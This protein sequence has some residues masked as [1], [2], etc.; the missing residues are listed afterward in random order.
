VRALSLL[1]LA[2]A[3]HAETRTYIVAVGNNAPP[4]ESDG[5]ELAPLRYADDD[6][7]AFYSFGR[8][9]ARSAY[10]LTVLDAA[11]QRRFPGL[12]EAA[13]PPTLA[14]L[15]RVVDELGRRFEADAREGHEPV[16]LL[17]FSGHGTRGGKRPP[18][19]ALLDEPLTQAVLYDDILSRLPARYVHLLVDAC[20]AEA[21]VRPRDT[22]AQP[23]DVT[24]EDVQTYAARAT[25]QR[26]PQVG[27]VLATAAGVQAHE[28]DAYQRGVFSHELLSALRG[29]ADVNGDGRIEYSELAAFLGA[30]NREVA[31]PRARL[32]VVIRPPSLNG[33]APL[34]D[35]TQLRGAVKLTG[36]A[37]GGLYVEDELGNRLADFHSEPGHPVVLLLPSD[38]ALFVHHGRREARLDAAAG[39]TIRLEELRFAESGFAAR[40]ALDLSLQRGL[41]ATAYG[42]RYYR[43]YVDQ[44]QELTPVPVPDEPLVTQ[45]PKVLVPKRTTGIALV[46]VGAGL[47]ATS[48]VL[49]GLAGDTVAHFPGFERQATD[50]KNRALAFESTAL[51]AAAL[52]LVAGGVGTWLMVRGKRPVRFAANLEW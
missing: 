9:V 27:A 35:T 38:R 12:A 50:A 20:H 11:S 33:R 40:G 1:L 18:S 52:A 37:A 30:A 47:A 41:F 7:A 16:L 45:P 2:A 24:D 51:T 48:I 13:R 5:E 23:V 39:A 22:S 21:V 19:L 10:L 42:P 44:N 46:A 15:K 8:A 26:F 28:W 34:I 29:A 25:L 14:E 49:G 31:D 3:A 43:G 17:F 6:A 4:V 36:R 32:S